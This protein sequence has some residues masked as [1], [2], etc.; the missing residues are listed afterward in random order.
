MGFFGT[1]ES[2]EIENKEIK[3]QVATTVKDESYIKTPTVNVSVINKLI[4]A[5]ADID[6]GGSLIVGGSFEGNVKIEDTLIIENRAT[7]KGNVKAKN[8]KIAGEFTGEVKA[9]VVEIGS[10]AKVIGI[11]NSNKAFLAG[12]IKAIIKSNDTIEVLESGNVESKGIKSGKI[13]INGR[14]Q[15]SVMASDLLEVTHKGSIKGTI[16]TKGIK[17][18]QGG[19]I[20]GNIQTYD[21]SL[22]GLDVAYS[23]EDVI[24]KEEPIKEEAKKISQ[25]EEK[26]LTK[27]A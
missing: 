5:K 15:G 7:F 24:K 22:H 16:I 6:G 21:E 1:N 11:I 18:E 20:I 14:V 13:K 2:E 25:L 26:D 27:Y 23:L 9:A 17:T 4:K 10:S 8:V 12:D 3:E 19:S